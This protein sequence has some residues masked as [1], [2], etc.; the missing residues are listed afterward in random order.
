MFL[1]VTRVAYLKEYQ[2]RLTFD[3]GV[4]KDVD[5]KD[6]LYG[7]IF[8]PLKDPNFFRQVQVNPETNTIEWPNGAD[9]APEFLYEIGHDVGE[10]A[11][12]VGVKAT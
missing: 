1:H 9:F 3:N 7:E 4:I 8:E 2:L 6:E 5:L 12:T 10:E 11:P